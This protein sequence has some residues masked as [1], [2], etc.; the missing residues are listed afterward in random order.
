[1]IYARLETE[2]EASGLEIMGALH[3]D[4]AGA[5]APSGGTL[6]LLGAGAGFWSVFS[7]SDEAHDGTPDPVDRWS[8]RVVGDLATQFD[9]EPIFP[10]EGPPHAPFIDWALKSGRAFASPTGM[11]V[12][13]KMGMMISYRGALHFS[14]EIAIPLPG[15]MSPCASCSGRPCTTACPVGALSGDMP[16]DVDACHDYLNSPAGTACIEQGCA[17]RRACPISA[18]AGRRPEQSAYHM[19]AFH[20]G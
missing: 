7:A 4:R 9:A 11:L 18:G 15:R 19:R 20:P 1:M 14:A 6:I 17:A 10:F 2:T 8:A 16:Y 12:H 3:P 5:R 13:D